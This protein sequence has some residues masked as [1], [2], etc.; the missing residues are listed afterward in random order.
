MIKLS[1]NLEI[2]VK[3][4]A[5]PLQDYALYGGG[6]ALAGA[7]I[8]GLINYLR[9]KSVGKGALIGGGLGGLAGLGTRGAMDYF[10]PEIGISGD[11][12]NQ[13]KQKDTEKPERSYTY[14][15]EAG[16]GDEAVNRY[17]QETAA[18]HKKDREESGK[19]LQRGLSKADKTLGSALQEGVGKIKSIGDE[20][21]P[22]LEWVQKLR[23]LENKLEA[24]AIPEGLT[25]QDLINLLGGVPVDPVSPGKVGPHNRSQAGLVR[26]EME[27]KRLLEQY[28]ASVAEDQR[29]RDIYRA[30]LAGRALPEQEAAIQAQI[31]EMNIPG[32]IHTQP[33]VVFDE[34]RQE[35]IRAQ[36][37]R[38]EQL[39][40]ARS[41][42]GS[43]GFGPNAPKR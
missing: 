27:G 10:A 35:R 7:G 18:R 31:E 26:A 8:G 13:D 42:L 41:A 12:E 4:S 25:E 5:S 1:S 19:R 28:R 38:R 21:K 39:D 30:L 29:Q 17:R 16:V 22:R 11:G 15:P 33:T 2:L 36:T 24:E 14:T 34:K 23:E 43:R 9:G 32:E 37:A 20:M 6:G 40:K 3:R